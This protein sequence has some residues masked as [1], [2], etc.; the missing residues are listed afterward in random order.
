MV[1][2]LYIDPTKNIGE[3]KGCI[4]SEL[5]KVGGAEA[6][7][8]PHP[9]LLSTVIHSRLEN[10]LSWMKNNPQNELGAWN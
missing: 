10:D 7:P 8:F 5:P 9:V 1:V 2:L 4:L 3:T 6:P